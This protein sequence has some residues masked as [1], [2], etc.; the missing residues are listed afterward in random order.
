VGPLFLEETIT[1][2]IYSNL[3][4]QFITL[5]KENKWDCWL[6]Q[7]EVTAHTVKTAAAF[8]QDFFGDHIV[9]HGL[10]PT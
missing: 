10:W 1:A 8:L 2:K 3:L 6:Q 9:G 4:T 5:L 7:C